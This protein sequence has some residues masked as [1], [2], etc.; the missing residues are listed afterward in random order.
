PATGAGKNR[1][2]SSR[3]QNKRS[4]DADD[5][6]C[7]AV[8]EVPATGPTRPPTPGPRHVAERAFRRKEQSEKS[9][10]E[11]RV[12]QV[13]PGVLQRK[14]SRTAATH[15]R[16]IASLSHPA[17]GLQRTTVAGSDGRLLDQ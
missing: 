17:R 4:D 14:R 6:D 9:A 11:S 2:H 3:K 8:R 10:G 16:G 12:P 13:D 5:V 7:R 1:R 15:R